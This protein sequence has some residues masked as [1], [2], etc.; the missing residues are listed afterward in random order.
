M[1]SSVKHL[2]TETTWPPES[3]DLVAFKSST[4]D[5]TATLH[6]V[7]WGLVWRD[8][9]LK[10]GRVIPEHRVSGCPHPQKWRKTADVTADERERC[11][12]R[13]LSMAQAGMDPRRRDET[14]WAELNQYLAY[15]YLRFKQARSQSQQNDQ[16]QN[17]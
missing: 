11:E 5:E 7:R 15:T 17:V 14:F 2:R 9:I 10:D 16:D 6:E 13:L 8:F 3:G 1:R 12:E 4:G